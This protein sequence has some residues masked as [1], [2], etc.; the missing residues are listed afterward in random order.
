[1]Q[2]TAHVDIQEDE[3]RGDW[4]VLRRLES[5]EG[6]ISLVAV[7]DGNGW[8]VSVEGSVLF[9]GLE[10]FGPLPKVALDHAETFVRRLSKAPSAD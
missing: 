3:G 7:S 5:P 9:Q 10:F 2:M 1:M 8:K 4:T 6:T